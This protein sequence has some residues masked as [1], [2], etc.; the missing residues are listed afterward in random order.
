[1]RDYIGEA[2]RE[3]LVEQVRLLNLRVAQLEAV[4][5]SFPTKLADPVRTLDHRRCAGMNSSPD[6][7]YVAQM[8][9]GPSIRESP[10]GSVPA[11]V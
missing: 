3:Y 8:S 10:L 5:A 6:A 4:V 9:L 2:Q 7:G 11:H 1:M